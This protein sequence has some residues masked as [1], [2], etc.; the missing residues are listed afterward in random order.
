MADA[1]VFRGV[2]RHAGKSSGVELRCALYSKLKAS[3]E[4]DIT[5]AAPC[6][7]F[8]LDRRTCILCSL[9]LA[10]PCY[11]SLHTRPCYSVAFFNWFYSSR[12]GRAVELASVGGGDPGP[13]SNPP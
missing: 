6:E 5:T 10:T 1:G 3:N 4:H 8:L 11:L 12:P 7:G 9:L 2:E 13:G